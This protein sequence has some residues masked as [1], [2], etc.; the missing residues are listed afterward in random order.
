MS[1][2]QYPL[3][4]PHDHAPPL[5]GL[6]SPGAETGAL[7]GNEF[8]EPA[9]DTDAQNPQFKPRIESVLM[10]NHGVGL[11]RLASSRQIQSLLKIQSSFSVRLNSFQNMMNSLEGWTTCKQ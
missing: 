5:S 1:G 7:Q 6:R 9:Q 10:S 8:S 2:A 4:H 11:E 3:L